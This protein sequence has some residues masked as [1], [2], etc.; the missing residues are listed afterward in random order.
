MFCL[1]ENR[2]SITEREVPAWTKNSL[3]PGTRLVVFLQAPCDAYKAL[4]RPR[5]ERTPPKPP[6]PQGRI[7]KVKMESNEGTPA[8][9]LG[10]DHFFI[11]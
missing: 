9:V 2:W 1:H 8:T 3:V 7:R 6:V 11:Q 10:Y 5:V 4:L